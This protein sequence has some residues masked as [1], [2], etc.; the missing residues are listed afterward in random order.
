MKRAKVFRRSESFFSIKKREDIPLSSEAVR[1]KELEFV[2]DGTA[3]FIEGLPN[4]DDEFN[5]G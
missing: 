5:C 1:F 4:N 2:N 3:P